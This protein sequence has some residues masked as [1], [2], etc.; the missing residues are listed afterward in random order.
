VAPLTVELD[1]YVESFANIAEANM[2]YTVFGYLRHFWIDKRFAGRFNETIRLK[3]SIVE[4]AWTPD[5]YVGNSRESNLRVKDSESDSMLEI[6]PNG[7]IFYSKGVKI[8]ASCEMNLENFP[9]DTQKCMLIFGSYSFN[10]N[11]LNYKWKTDTAIVEKKSIAQFDMNKVELN[12][13]NTTYIS[14]SYST[15]IISFNFKRRIGYYVI[16]V[17]FPD[18]LVVAI[19]WIVF[20]LDQDDMGGRV[21]LGITTI[22]TIMFLL[23]S[24]NMSLPRVSYPK[25]IDW[26]LIGSFLFVFLVVM[27]CILVYILRP[28]NRDPKNNNHKKVM[29]LEMG[30]ISNVQVGK[31]HGKNSKNT[32]RRATS[33]I[34]RIFEELNNPELSVMENM[35][36]QQQESSYLSNGEAVQR[37][38]KESLARDKKSLER[39][40]S[41]DCGKTIDRTSRFLFP[42]AFVLF[43]A[44]YWYRYLS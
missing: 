10:T 44:F 25:A 34:W 7:S 5:T 28:R 2:E 18:I 21:G 16:Q 15:L 37:D 14:G 30:I 33:A 3:G 8:V 43:N 27:E 6:Y 13:T 42:F 31:K 9:M 23:G 40:K 11:G 12:S 41:C 32:T 38:I 1:L 20:W 24:V 39:C 4:H 26:Y 19:S 22:L 35:A 36:V 29:E 17:F